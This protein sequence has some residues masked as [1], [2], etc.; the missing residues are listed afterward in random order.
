VA[1]TAGLF[2]PVFA[3]VRVL[4]SLLS[5]FV[6]G[7]FVLASEAWGTGGRDGE[8]LQSGELDGN[9]GDRCRPDPAW[10]LKAKTW[11]R[12][13]FRRRTGSRL[14]AADLANAEAR[15]ATGESCAQPE[16][17]VHEIP[18]K[19]PGG[20]GRRFRWLA[21]TWNFGFK[22]VL[23]EIAWPLLAGLLLSG[24]LAA[25]LPEDFA[26]F[27]PGGVFGQMVFSA[28]I[29][30]PL[31]LCASASTP[32]GAVLVAKGLAP[33][34]VLVL[35]L[36]GPVTNAPS[37][38]VYRR[39]FGKKFLYSI[40]LATLF[41]SFSMGAV[42]HVLT[43]RI[44]PNLREEVTF[45]ERGV[46]GWELVAAIAF[47]GPFL[48]SLVRVGWKEG[49]EQVV[50]AF[51][52]L[53]PGRVLRGLDHGLEVLAGL[54]TRT[55][56]AGLLALGLFTWLGFGFV[57]VPQ[58]S[59]GYSKILGRAS[60][61]PMSPGL[62]WTPP[63][64]LGS[65]VIVPA[66]ELLRLDLGYRAA[67]LADANS[68]DWIFAGNS[69]HAVYTTPGDNPEE[70]SFVTGD[71]NL[72]EAKS[73]IHLRI[74]DSFRYAFEL[75]NGLEL[76]RP[77]A[78]SVLKRLF[79]SRTIDSVLSEGR[80]ALEQEA[81]RRLSEALS[82]ARL[83]LQ[84]VSFNL[85]DLHPPQ[86]A[87]TAFRD[88]GSASEDRERRKYEARGVAESL[89]PKARGEAAVQGARAQADAAERRLLAEGSNRAFVS[90]VEGMR[91]APEEARMRLYWETF[92]TVLG[93]RK[94]IIAPGYVTQDIIQ[95]GSAPLAVLPAAPG[96]TK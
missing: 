25:A 77:I 30:V 18:E 6:A 13:T 96:T 87:V 88:V 57:S 28:V 36:T 41:V 55:Y 56:L 51:R 78:L 24:F 42:L 7:L 74:T 45:L 34:A 4:A 73:T 82:G 80:G 11:L 19:E 71:Q 84:V 27:I 10:W 23:D 12:G 91:G 52:G 85:L 54:P 20:K 50:S 93:G 63:P 5:G 92:G 17:H 8:G 38:L 64:L 83:P 62:H 72:L 16:T 33:A 47:A 68:D 21:D 26:K 37:V 49:S 61:E 1:L 44:F 65:T 14:A 67:G 95:G 58:G 2:G 53:V 48:L 40:L 31:Y 79:A 3:V 76:V 39:N 46:A 86:G 43:P 66:S 9:D 81:S 75:E 59:L 90:R 70:A 60:H 15:P 22:E 69:W 94:V 29:A 89:L 32:L 35:F